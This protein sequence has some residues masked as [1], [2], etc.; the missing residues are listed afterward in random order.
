MPASLIN[1]RASYLITPNKIILAAILHCDFVVVVVRH[2]SG[3]ARSL[4]SARQCGATRPGA[5]LIE[6]TI[7]ASEWAPIGSIDG[8]AQWAA[9]RGARVGRRDRRQMQMQMRP[10]CAQ[11][12]AP[13]RAPA[14]RKL[15]GRRRSGARAPKRWQ[16]FTLKQFVPAHGPRPHT[17]TRRS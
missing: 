10:G 15:E 2:Q 6:Q 17:L 9:P 4:T 7:L 1:W 14:N 13:A 3:A 12:I 16:N 8:R 11:L 5:L